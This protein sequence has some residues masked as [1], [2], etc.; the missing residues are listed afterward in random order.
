MDVWL[1]GVVVDGWLIGVE[2]WMW[3]D[4]VAHGPEYGGKYG[5]MSEYSLFEY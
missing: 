2:V 5:S 4:R 3:Y 1:I